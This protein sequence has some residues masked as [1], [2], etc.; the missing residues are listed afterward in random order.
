MLVPP[1]LIALAKNRS[2]LQ[3][4][5]LSSLR[6]IMTGAAPTGHDL[7]MDVKNA[8]PSVEQI[9]QGY[10]LTEVSMA[11][12]LPVYGKDNP[13]AV[14][15]LAAN[16][17]MKVKRIRARE[18]NDISLFPNSLTNVLIGS[19]YRK[20]NTTSIWQTRRNLLPR[21]YNHG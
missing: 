13:T 15:R 6:F 11:S 19:R 1:I 17:E 21:S 10:G 14:G 4:Y 2:K 3:K 12:H 5:D 16:Y 8:I 20:G 18:G 7:I 9:A